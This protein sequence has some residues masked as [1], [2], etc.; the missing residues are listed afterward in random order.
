MQKVI[1]FLAKVILFIAFLSVFGWMVKH[2]TKGDK[3]F[4]FLNTPLKELSGFPDMFKQSVKEVK[5]LPGT[6]I[7]TYGSS[8]KSTN[9]LTEDAKALI[10]YSNPDKNRTID[11]YN[12]K[13]EKP[14]H[15]WQVDMTGHGEH[16]RIQAPLMYE[17]SSLIYSCNRT[18]GFR[19]I[20][21]NSELIWEQ[22]SIISHHS[23]E[24]DHEGNVWGC[25]YNP[26]W[27]QAIIFKS[28]YQVDS[29]TIRFIDNS[30][31]KVDSE[32]GRILY[33]KSFSEILKE[34]SLNYL[35]VKSGNSEDPLHMNDVQPALK[36]T[37]WY[38]QGDVFISSRNLSAIIHYRPETEKVIR[39]LE[40]PFVCQHDVDFLNDSTILFFNNNNGV[41]S[42]R[43]TRYIKAP[44]SLT[45]IEMGR[46][47]SELMTYNLASKTYK[48]IHNEVMSENRIFTKTEGLQEKYDNGLMFVEEQNTGELWIL[49][50]DTVV[51]N[52]V[53]NS[54]HEGYHHLPNWI[55]IVN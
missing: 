4:G 51:Y 15:Q 53:L 33:N 11:L 23:L 6:F 18:T 2:V 9:K 44:N 26:E 52:N 21:K 20:D 37:Q 27:N 49:N 55:R 17:D 16:V 19:R 1:F 25:T 12:F 47:N 42:G 14:E 41:Y 28:F 35:V 43:G 36:T 50:G 3:D 46:N 10:A 48:P 40:G 32:T 7:K 39:V 13:T 31:T 45:Q 30:I 54:H 34:N 22:D 24:K 8:Y 38:N 5:G 29:D